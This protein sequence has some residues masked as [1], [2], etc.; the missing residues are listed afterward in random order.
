MPHVPPPGAWS[1]ATPAEAGMRADA[2]AAAE[3]FALAAE[4]PWPVELG[5]GL[6]ADPDSNEPPPWNE[7]LGPTR[8]R[9][10]PNGLVVRGGRVVASWGDPSRVDMTFSVTKSYLAV[11]AGIAVGDGLIRDLDDPVRDYAL[12]D[13]F[14][15]AQNRD[16]TWRHLLQ[17]TSE[18]EGTLFGKPDLIDRNRQVGPG[19]DNS[20]KGTHRDLQPPGRF[21]EYN[22]VR[23]NRLSLSL[24]QVFRRPLPEVLRERVM[25]PI[26]ASATWEWHPYRNAWVDIDGVSLPSVPGGAH[27]GGGLFISSEDHARVGLLVQRGGRWGDRQVLPEGWCE[28]MFRAC[29]INARYGLLWW[30][31]TGRRHYPSAPATSAFAIGA[32][33]SMIWVDA[34]LDLTMVARWVDPAR[35]DALVAHVMRAFEP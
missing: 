10:G 11:V 33:Q 25:D 17:Q 32:G 7:V 6:A 26:G 24:L 16:V 29:P 15:S 12:D 8:D 14:E 22:D 4:T 23:V 21:W 9:G 30:L 35:A 31:N 2:L 3:R 28:E 5:A 34:A 18:W 13:G 1:T 19:S 20:R 27:W